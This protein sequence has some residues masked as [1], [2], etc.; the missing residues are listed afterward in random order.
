MGPKSYFE[1]LAPDPDR[2]IQEKRWMGIDLIETPRITR[3]AFSTDQIDQKAK[4]LHAY[5]PH[6]GQV[7]KGE[8]QT[9]NGSCIRWMMTLPYHSPLID[10]APFYIDW[11]DSPA[12]PSEMLDDQSI[13]LMHIKVTAQNLNPIKNLYS[14]LKL[15]TSIE[16]G[17]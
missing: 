2:P 13:E 4:L 17:N 1:I 14:L 9:S 7:S 12:H 15:E 11:S 5:D 16:S 10:L 3:I 6:L 8:R